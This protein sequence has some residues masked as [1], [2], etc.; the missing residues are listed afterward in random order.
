MTTEQAIERLSAI[1]DAK[2]WWIEHADQ[3]TEMD[4]GM[5]YAPKNEETI[6]NIKELCEADLEALELATMAL[7]DKLRDVIQVVRCKDCKWWH[8]AHCE[9]INGAGEYISNP[10]WYC[11]S[12]ERKCDG[13]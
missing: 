1:Y 10:Y 4:G 12:G 6:K 13:K 7:E 2:K 8:D 5:R 3:I 11:C 9:N